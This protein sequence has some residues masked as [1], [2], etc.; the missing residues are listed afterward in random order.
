[1]TPP[2]SSCWYVLF[3]FACLSETDAVIGSSSV[4]SLST[5]CVSILQYWNDILS[6]H[7]RLPSPDQA[8]SIPL[9]HASDL[10]SKYQCNVCHRSAMVSGSPTICVWSQS[11][12]I[13]RGA[14]VRIQCFILHVN[15]YWWSSFQ[16]LP[17]YECEAQLVNSFCNL[18]QIP[19]YI[20]I[21]VVQRFVQ[22]LKYLM[23][24]LSI[25]LRLAQVGSNV[26][27]VAHLGF[28]WTR[29]SW[30][31]ECLGMSWQHTCE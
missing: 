27:S 6:Q 19:Q 24:V 31:L 9:V 15:F 14:Y 30:I 28:L 13:S 16:V 4:V 17:I 1:M 12:Q 18:L 8:D 3:S 7:H 22:M 23:I 20:I 29:R 21:F 25:L 26:D 10:T 2:S 5:C 11:H